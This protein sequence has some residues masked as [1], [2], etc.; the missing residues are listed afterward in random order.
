MEA[1]LG[2]QARADNAQNR[3]AM[4]RICIPT[5]APRQENNS[6]ARG[7][8]SDVEI[9]EIAAVESGIV[10]AGIGF[11]EAGFGCLRVVREQAA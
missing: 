3:D 1:D 7:F 4:W 8:P 11:V 10:S 5:S 9:S 6:P 2:P